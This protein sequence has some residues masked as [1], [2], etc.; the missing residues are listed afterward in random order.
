VQLS[1]NNDHVEELV[2]RPY[3]T[4]GDRQRGFILIDELG[5]RERPLLY[6]SLRVRESVC[7]LLPSF[8][9]VFFSEL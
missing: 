5:L 8:T 2:P 6:R 7:P 9:Y 1:S 4:P 3:G